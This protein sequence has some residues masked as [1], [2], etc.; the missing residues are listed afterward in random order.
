MN[1]VETLMEQKSTSGCIFVLIFL[2]FESLNILFFED[3][4]QGFHQAFD[5]WNAQRCAEPHR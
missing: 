2:V 4:R 5:S 3:R 1:G